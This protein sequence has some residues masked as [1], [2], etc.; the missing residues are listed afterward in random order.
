MS[1]RRDPFACGKLGRRHRRRNREREDVFLRHSN[2]LKYLEKERNRTE[3]GS[4]GADFVPERALVRPGEKSHR[5][6]NA[7]GR[8]RRRFREK[9]DSENS[10][11]D[12]RSRTAFFVPGHHRLHARASRTGRL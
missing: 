3:R 8:F 9:V 10:C 6:F 11:F 4:L 12:S 1:I 7:S 5:Y 2:R